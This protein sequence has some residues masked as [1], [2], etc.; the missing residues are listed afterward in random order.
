[1]SVSFSQLSTLVNAETE[2][3]KG[4]MW[5]TGA[6]AVIFVFFRFYT[7]I[8]RF[9]RLY[10]DDFFAFM[11]AAINVTSIIIWQ[12]LVVHDLYEVINGLRGFQRL[13]SEFA[14]HLRRYFDTSFAVF[15]LFNSMLWAIKFSFLIFF[16]RL[17]KHVPRQKLL[18][19]PILAFTVV[20]YV[21]TVVILGANFCFGKSLLY[22]VQTCGTRSASRKN[23]FAFILG[24]V[25]DI[26]TDVASEQSLSVFFFVF[27]LLPY[28]I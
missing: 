5:G 11:A 9:K 7:R 21:I 16:K 26:L 3:I 24:F 13:K 1:M 28:L 14:A 23:R 8:K 12:T 4:V 15:I 18:W 2:M 10:W 27:Y 25:M 22:V 20:S 17:G 19:W 6:I